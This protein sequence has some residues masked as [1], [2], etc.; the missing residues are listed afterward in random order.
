M[1]AVTLRIALLLAACAA[2][3]GNGIGTSV[4][5]PELFAKLCAGCHGPTGKPPAS[6]AVQLGVRDLTSPELRARIT[7]VLV[8]RQMRRGSD[9]KLMPSFELLMNDAQMKAL[10]SYVASPAFL[11]RR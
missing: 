7:P 1:A 4:E 10:A 11:D 9:N 3:G 5:G 6:L 2:C 8:E